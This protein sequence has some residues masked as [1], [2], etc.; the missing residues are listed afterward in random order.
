MKKLPTTVSF[1]LFFSIF[2][3]IKNEF[4]QSQTKKLRKKF[5]NKGSFFSSKK[6]SP[7]YIKSR[8]V[9][10]KSQ[11]RQKISNEDGINK[12][13]KGQERKNAA[14]YRPRNETQ[15]ILKKGLC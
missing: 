2:T 5:N 10:L 13:S 3:F 1:L 6:T 12:K 4:I 15:I 8:N 9:L 11:E 7:P 14:I